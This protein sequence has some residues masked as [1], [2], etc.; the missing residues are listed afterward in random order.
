MDVVFAQLHVRDGDDREQPQDHHD[1]GR[2]EHLRLSEIRDSSAA[3][4]E[5]A[6]EAKRLA[7]LQIGS[8]LMICFRV[9]GVPAGILGLANALPRVASPGSSTQ[10]SA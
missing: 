2:L 6:V 5:Q 3:R 4:K 9:G 7:E 1:Q 10:A 8:V